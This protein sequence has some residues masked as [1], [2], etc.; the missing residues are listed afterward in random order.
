M[1]AVL[2]WFSYHEDCTIYEV[3]LCEIIELSSYVDHKKSD[4]ILLDAVLGQK[5][6]WSWKG[7]LKNDTVK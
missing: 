6:S 7:M 2:K 5:R 1:Q 4:N 3:F